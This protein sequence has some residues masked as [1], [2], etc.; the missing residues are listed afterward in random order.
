MFLRISLKSSTDLPPGMALEQSRSLVN[1]LSSIGENELMPSMLYN[2]LIFG[3][4]PF[5][6]LQVTY[7]HL[8]NLTS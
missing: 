1:Y 5:L 2:T 8:K 6:L 4:I 7:Q 3:I